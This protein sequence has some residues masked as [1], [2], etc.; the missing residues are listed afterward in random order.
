MIQNKQYLQEKASAIIKF[1][2]I[3]IFEHIDPIPPNLYQTFLFISNSIYLFMHD[4]WKW[5]EGKRWRRERRIS[6]QMQHMWSCIFWQD[7]IW[8]PPEQHARRTAVDLNISFFM[9]FVIDSLTGIMTQI[10]SNIMKRQQKSPCVL[11]L[12]WRGRHLQG[13]HYVSSN[14]QRD[15]GIFWDSGSLNTSKGLWFITK[16]WM[17]RLAT[18]Y[19]IGLVMMFMTTEK[20]KR[21]TT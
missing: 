15:R 21:L 14:K 18:C 16:F 9:D 5:L 8:T 1:G 11:R 4:Q 13:V 12:F 3:G 19:R 2:F 10:S 17:I 7:R 6:L 20:V